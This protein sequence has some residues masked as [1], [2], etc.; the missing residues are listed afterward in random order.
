MKQLG[1]PAA[2][3]SMRD[4][5]NEYYWITIEQVSS[6]SC[7]FDVILIMLRAKWHIFNGLN[8][9]LFSVSCTASRIMTTVMVFVS[10]VTLP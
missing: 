9:P 7:I 1:Y 3:G 5:F 2:S 10:P 6:K 4:L 8:L